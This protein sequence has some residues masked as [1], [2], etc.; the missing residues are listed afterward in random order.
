MAPAA[1]STGRLR[2]ALYS[3][4]LPGSDG[5][6]GVVTYTGIMRDGLQTLGHSVIIV[7]PNQIDQDGLVTELS[8]PNPII[9]RMKAFAEA[10]RFSDGSTPWSRLRLYRAFHAA[11]RA[12]A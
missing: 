1:A 3:P 5:S 12:G 10:R 7:T 6:N 2:V 9:W 11:Q 4:A 8:R